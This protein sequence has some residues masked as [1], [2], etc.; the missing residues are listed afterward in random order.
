MKQSNIFFLLSAATLII[1]LA[2]CGKTKLSQKI[3]VDPATSAKV[4]FGFFTPVSA[5]TNRGVQ[6]KVNGV[7]V[8]NLLTYSI[9]FPGGGF[10][11]GGQTFADYI[12]VD[13]N[14][15]EQPVI[16][17]LSIPALNTNSDSAILFKG[18]VSLV[19]DSKQTV[20]FT[21]TFP[22]I[23]ATVLRDD[24]PDP[25]PGNAKFKFFNGI[26]N[27]GNIDFYVASTAGTFLAAG[28]VP[29]KGVSGYFETPV[30]GL[31]NITFSMVRAGMPNITANLI[32]GGSSTNHPY[33]ATLL[34]NGR[35]YN[36]NAR[37]YNGV[38]LTDQRRPL[39]SIT[40]IK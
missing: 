15:A 6:L 29:Y 24:T 40:P 4:K 1:L 8:T 10:N 16:L 30:T 12:T 18:P 11:Q 33:N 7:R 32:G 2:G 22:N 19:P 23:Q 9:T 17:T 26:P 14:A 21:D 37:G 28:N 31:G 13:A 20:M 34:L 35:I 25:V 3:E 36:V 39:P 5:V 27:A 38:A